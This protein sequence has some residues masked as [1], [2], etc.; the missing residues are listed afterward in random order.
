M[1]YFGGK[2]KIS[3]DLANVLN[4]ITKGKPFVDLFCGA[5][6]V[7]EKITTASSRMANDNNPYLIAL[8]KAIQGGY[9][10]PVVVSEE[11]YQY[12]M[13]HLD[14]NPALSGFIGIACS[15]SGGW[16]NGYVRSDKYHTNYAKDGYNTLLRQKSKLDGVTFTS[17]SY[18][19]LL[20]PD[21]AVI[22]CD[23]PYRNKRKHYYVNKFDYDAF[24]EWVEVNKEKYDIYISEYKENL[25]SWPSSYEIVWEKESCQEMSKRKK[26]TEVLIHAR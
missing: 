17:C 6:N 10:P 16:K 26:T 14:E 25:F 20:I 23:P 12:T 18:D 21:G 8:L 24:T 3:K 9:E 19:R 4:P 7:V 15:F 1:H 11:E 5:C 22:Y 2:Y 13:N